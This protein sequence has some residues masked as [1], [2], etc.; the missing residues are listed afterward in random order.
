MKNIGVKE[1]V[2]SV[3]IEL[4]AELRDSVIAFAEALIENNPF[5]ETTSIEKIKNEY[6]KKFKKDLKEKGVLD[7]AAE[8]IAKYT[9]EKVIEETLNKDVQ[10]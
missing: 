8:R 1:T 6:I 7:N 10:Y 2:K 3:D 4:R 9:A 5:A